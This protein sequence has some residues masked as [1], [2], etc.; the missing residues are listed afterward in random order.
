M[1]VMS[2]ATVRNSFRVI[3]NIFS[4]LFCILDRHYH[5]TIWIHRYL[6]R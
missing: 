4:V 3:N 1:F 2:H 6:N 5:I